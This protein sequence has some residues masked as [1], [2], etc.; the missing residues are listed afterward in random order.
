[1][2]PYENNLGDSEVA[3][4]VEKASDDGYFTDLKFIV[5]VLTGE[6]GLETTG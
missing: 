5:T 3:L 1:L 4:R 6:N 2:E